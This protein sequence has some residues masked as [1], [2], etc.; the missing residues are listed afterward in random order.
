L[1]V[2]ALEGTGVALHLMSVNS[3]PRVKTDP[4]QGRRQLDATVHTTHVLAKR[5]IVGRKIEHDPICLAAKAL[6]L[7]LRAA[8][9]D[10]ALA[11]R[12]VG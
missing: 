12:T 4:N 10:P 1:A 9:V 6:A 11:G 5:P 7:M 8:E 2:Q 3:K